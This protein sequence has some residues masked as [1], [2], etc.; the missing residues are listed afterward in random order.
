MTKVDKVRQALQTGQT[1]MLIAKVLFRPVGADQAIVEINGV[2]FTIDYVDRLVRAGVRVDCD[3]RKT[4][5]RGVKTQMDVT[6]LYRRFPRLGWGD[7][8][9]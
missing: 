6:D 2:R 5:W 4:N 1:S 8:K 3:T 7:F 9:I